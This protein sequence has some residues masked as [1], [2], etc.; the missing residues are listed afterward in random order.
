MSFLFSWVY[1]EISQQYGT[2]FI[3]YNKNMIFYWKISV[4]VE[5][6]FL[7]F[8]AVRCRIYEDPKDYKEY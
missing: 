3:L 5:G 4:K 6:K 8:K 1:V 7:M 2:I